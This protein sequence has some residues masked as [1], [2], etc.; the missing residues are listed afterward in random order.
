MQ[1]KQSPSRDGTELQEENPYKAPNSPLEEKPK[2]RNMRE[3]L[4]YQA[5]KYENLSWREVLKLE[6]RNRW[7]WVFLALMAFLLAF[8]LFMKYINQL[9]PS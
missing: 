8:I 4:E 2:Y 3:W 9:P 5:R 1:E 7:N 6:L